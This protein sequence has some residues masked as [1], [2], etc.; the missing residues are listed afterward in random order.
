MID[1]WPLDYRAKHP[2]ADEWAKGSR[3]VRH[4]LETQGRVFRMVEQLRVNRPSARTDRLFSGHE[5]VD[6]MVD[7]RDV[8]RTA[9]AA[10]VA[11]FRTLFGIFPPM[12]DGE[13][14]EGFERVSEG[15]AELAALG[16]QALGFDPILIDGGDPAAYVWAL[17]EMQ[18]RKVGCAEVG[19]LGQH[20]P[21][22]PR[23]LAIIAEASIRQ[24]PPA[25]REPQLSR[26][27]VGTR[28]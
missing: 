18:Q 23:C 28:R 15:E 6:A 4:R 24:S 16:L 11:G 9:A 7:A 13:L 8:P 17:F 21:L 5:A 3:V 25:V 22:Q 26:Q 10:G 2:S 27:L 20:A 14:P 19:R 12:D 1:R